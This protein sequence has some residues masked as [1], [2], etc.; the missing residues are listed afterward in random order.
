[1]QKPRA[2]HSDPN[3]DGGMGSDCPVTFHRLS[4]ESMWSLIQ[5]MNP[6]SGTSHTIIIAVCAVSYEKKHSSGLEITSIH[7]WFVHLYFMTNHILCKI[8]FLQ[9]ILLETLVYNNTRFY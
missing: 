5:L 6:S 7:T 1:M 9:R 8:I 2:V 3:W 4:M